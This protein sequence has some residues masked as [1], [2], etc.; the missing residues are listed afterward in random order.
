[1][2]F[3]AFHSIYYNHIYRIVLFAQKMDGNLSKGFHVSY[4]IPQG[5]VLG[6]V[7]G[8]LFFLLFVNDLPKVSK[9]ETTLFVDDT[10]LHLSHKNINVV[11][12]QVAEEINKV[13]QWIIANKLTINYK[14]SCYMIISN[15]PQTSSYH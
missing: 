9:F 5:S 7:L 3:V 15:K 6:S 12:C 8:P 10:N 13:N 2:D 4:G 11:H 14:K 1:M